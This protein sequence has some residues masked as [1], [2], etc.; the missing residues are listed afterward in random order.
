M[1]CAAER[2]RGETTASYASH[3]GR[4][5]SVV[6]WNHASQ[7]TVRRRRFHGGRS[8]PVRRAGLVRVREMHAACV[9]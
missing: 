9:E 3:A 4:I 5:F 8:S 2:I 7:F 1:Y 6:N